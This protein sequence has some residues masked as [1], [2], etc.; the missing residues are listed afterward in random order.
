M[1]HIGMGKEEKYILLINANAMKIIGVN[2][3]CCFLH[4]IFATVKIETFSSIGGL[5]DSVSQIIIHICC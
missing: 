4:D 5:P 2:S 3:S 1:S